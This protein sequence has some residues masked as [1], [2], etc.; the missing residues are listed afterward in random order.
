MSFIHAELRPTRVDQK[1][2][3]KLLL[4]QQKW[5]SHLYLL[6]LCFI[7]SLLV[8][9][10]FSFLSTCFFSFLSTCFL[11]VFF[12]LYLFPLCFPF[13]LLVLWFTYLLHLMRCCLYSCTLGSV[14]QEWC[15]WGGRKEEEQYEWRGGKE[16][17]S[18]W[19]CCE[20]SHTVLSEQADYLKGWGFQGGRGRLRREGWEGKGEEETREERS[21]GGGRG[22]EVTPSGFCLY[23]SNYIP[24]SNFTIIIAIPRICSRSLQ[25][26]YQNI[27]W[28][29]AGRNTWV[30]YCLPI[31]WYV[32]ISQ[33]THL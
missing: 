30:C 5:G 27:S 7:S 20:D 29:Q 16:E 11:S 28:R 23:W 24:V 22:V 1:I 14:L 13:S 26:T 2:I 12:P 17:K 10:L 32:H 33:S 4:H 3:L 18:C 6:S 21:G 31:W 8:S 9:S 15:G 25:R 19:Y